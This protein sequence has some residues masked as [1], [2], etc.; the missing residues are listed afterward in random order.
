MGM[1]CCLNSGSFFPASVLV[2]RVLNN[3]IRLADWEEMRLL[4]PHSIR[5][6]TLYGAPDQAYI[7]PLE[8]NVASECFLD[9]WQ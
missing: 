2:T 7:I 8:A 4:Q 3:I 6:V 1:S 9:G 5:D